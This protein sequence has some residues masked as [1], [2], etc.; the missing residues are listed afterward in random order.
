MTRLIILI[1]LPWA[2][3]CCVA[4]PRPPACAARVNRAAPAAR[5]CGLRPRPWP[6][7]AT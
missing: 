1:G 3:G 7:P 6:R 5:R 4:P 2:G